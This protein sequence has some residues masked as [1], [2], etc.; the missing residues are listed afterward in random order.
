MLTGRLAFDGNTRSDIVAGILEREPDWATVPP[1][2]PAAVRRLLRRC[3]E[4]DHRRRI[5]DVG[6]IKLELEDIAS[7]EAPSDSGRAHAAVPAPTRNRAWLR[8]V[9]LAAAGLLVG[10]LAAF[11]WQRDGSSGSN[12]VRFT[13]TLPEDERIATTELGAVA[14]SPDG[15]S[16]VYVAGRGN[17]TQLMLRALDSGTARPLPGTSGA[18]SPFFSQIGRASCRERVL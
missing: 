9:A 8:S 4:K 17:T 7:T 13:I 3:L 6:D 14:M 2:T 16:I 1:D 10:F 5:R 15:R 11:P 18:V 12:E